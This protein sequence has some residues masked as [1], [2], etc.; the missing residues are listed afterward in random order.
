MSPV[1]YQRKAVQHR[2][3]NVERGFAH[4]NFSYIQVSPK[5]YVFHYPLVVLQRDFAR[6][7][8]HSPKTFE[9]ARMRNW[10]PHLPGTRCI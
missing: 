7:D 5:N 1:S 10:S 3:Q 9:T 8:N 4:S 2:M 6:T